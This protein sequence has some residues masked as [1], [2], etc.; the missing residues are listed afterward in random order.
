MKIC[1]CFCS[2]SVTITLFL[3]ILS[4]IEVNLNLAKMTKYLL[5]AQ[6][7]AVLQL[8]TLLK[9]LPQQIKLSSMCRDRI[10]L[11]VLQVV[12]SMCL[13]LVNSTISLK[14]FNTY[15]WS[16]D[17]GDGGSKFLSLL[18]AVTVEQTVDYHLH[19]IFQI[20]ILLT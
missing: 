12:Q 15:K 7:K 6:H 19:N 3:T 4:L 14:D 8:I 18:D 1:L 2:Q 13:K 20:I 11:N 5:L 17:Q 10:A 16:L 9:N